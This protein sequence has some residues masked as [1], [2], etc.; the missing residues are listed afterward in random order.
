MLEEI[1]GTLED[2]PIHSL[3]EAT[4]VFLKERSVPYRSIEKRVRTFGDVTVGRFRPPPAKPRSENLLVN[5]LEPFAG[6]LIPLI[7]DSSFL[8]YRS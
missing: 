8:S 5:S 4:L 3:S 7:H 6:Y 2:V 1:Y